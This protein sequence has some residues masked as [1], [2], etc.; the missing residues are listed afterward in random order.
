LYTDADDV[1][2]DNT[3]SVYALDIVNDVIE[4]AIE[5]TTSGAITGAI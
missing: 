4:E 2:I 5:V 3:K 1:E